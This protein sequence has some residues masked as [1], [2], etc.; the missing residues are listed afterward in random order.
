ME[1][2]GD[3]DQEGRAE[4][5]AFVEE[6]RSSTAN[7]AHT[8][9]LNQ[10]LAEGERDLK[11]LRKKCKNTPFLAAAVMSQE[12]AV[13][14]MK[15]GFS[16][17]KPIYD[18]H[19]DHAHAIRDPSAT[20]SYYLAQSQGEYHQVMRDTVDILSNPDALSF[21]DILADTSAYPPPGLVKE[22]PVVV[23]QQNSLAEYAWNLARN[24]VRY[25]AGAMAWHDHGWPGLLVLF[26]SPLAAD[27]QFAWKQLRED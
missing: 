4:A 19:S 11:E 26:Q 12:H 22:S 25:R 23:K 20:L 16:C 18:H 17:M 14:L 24:L 7:A 9:D 6:T 1:A 15:I 10:S 8:A 3:D 2:A 27:R 13:S 21:M 5:A